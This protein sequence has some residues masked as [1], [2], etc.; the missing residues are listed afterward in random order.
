MIRWIILFAI[1]AAAVVPRSA[2]GNGR[3]PSTSSITFQQGSQQGHEQNIVAG[4]TFGVLISHD[5]GK[6][7]AWMCEDAIGY[8]GT[9]DPRYAYTGTGALF[10]TT[11]NGLK[12]MRDGCSF[13]DTPE[14]SKF[15]SASTLGPDQAFYYAA[16]Q[17]ADAAHGVTSDFQVY[18]SV[19]DGMTFPNPTRPD[20]PADT[21]V[22]WE[23]LMVAPSNAQVVYLSGY[24][25]IPNPTGGTM[26]D[27][28][29][30]RSDNGGTSWTLLAKTGLALM[31]NS[32]IHIVGIT[33]DDA[34]HVYARVEL[35]DN[36]LSD[37][38]YVSTD[39]GVSWKEIRRKTAAIGAFVVRAALNQGKHDLVLGTQAL[40]TEVSHD[41]GTTW[42]AVANAPHINCLVENS[43]NELWACTQ[44]YGFSGI[45]SDDAGIMK[46]TD[47]VTWTKVLHYQDL[48]NA[49]DCAT[50]TVQHDTCAPMWCTVCMQLGCTAAASYNCPVA[51]EAPTMMP[52][53]PGKS[54][55]CCDTGASAG[56][57]L[58]LALS[59]ATI[60]LRPR[61]RR[62]P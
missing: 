4:M 20:D 35:V 13:G 2:L 10:A 53:P 18:R 23:S 24:R 49:V 5:G 38:I 30:Y 55:G 7:W 1:A 58:A 50:G 41:D 16:S 47:L 11:F 28:L 32:V 21:N 15:V 57:P 59:V 17:T 51:T 44:N 43:A 6:T 52:P 3:A 19:N 45:A 60:V 36:T 33:R 8:K 62:A 40:G 26:R 54:G 61:R 29:L 27:H 14:G 42:T 37:A 9:Y 39:S 56:G 31:P 48:T 22:W 34:R 46:T 12:V 25:Y